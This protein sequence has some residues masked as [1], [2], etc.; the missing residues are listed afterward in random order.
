VGVGL[1]SFYFI[2]SNPSDASKA[3][4]PFFEMGLLASDGFAFIIVVVLLW[5]P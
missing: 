4:R 2:Y 3:I 1:A 5:N